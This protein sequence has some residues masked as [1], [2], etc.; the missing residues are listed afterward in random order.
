M[1]SEGRTNTQIM[2][3]IKKNSHRKKNHSR[4]QLHEWIEVNE[5]ILSIVIVIKYS[6]TIIPVHI[7]Y[8]HAQLYTVHTYTK[9][10]TQKQQLIVKWA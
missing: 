4:I 10:I 7:S 5:Y 6:L 2:L 1:G 9:D 8:T 3:K